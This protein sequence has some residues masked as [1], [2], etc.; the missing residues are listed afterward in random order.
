MLVHG[1]PYSRARMI[2]RSISD[3]MALRNFW[4]FRRFSLDLL[5]PQR[6]RAG[7]DPAP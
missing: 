1:I 6:A 3:S 4:T 7:G 2:S 5:C